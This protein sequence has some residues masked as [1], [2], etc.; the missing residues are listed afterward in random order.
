MSRYVVARTTD[1]PDG[2]RLLVEVNGRAIGIFNVSGRYY[3][4]VNRCPH[5]GGPMCKGQLVSRLDAA[6]PGQYT[7]DASRKFLACPWHGWE[8]DLETGRSYFDPAQA[9]RAFPVDVAPGETL[10]PEIEAGDV[11]G[12]IEGPFTAEKIPIVVEDEY[13]VLTLKAPA[14]AAAGAGGAPSS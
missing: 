2:E 3:A 13:L 14:S 1:V 9:L 7:I 10:A 8:F 11:Q 5:A 6:R 12:L 4:F